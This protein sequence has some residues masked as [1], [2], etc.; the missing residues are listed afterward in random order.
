MNEFYDT[1]APFFRPISFVVNLTIFLSC[2]F[3]V[4][5]GQIPAWHKQLIYFMAWVALCICAT[6]MVGM[7]YGREHTF[8]YYQIGIIFES[9]FN[10]AVAVIGVVFCIRYYKGAYAEKPVTKV[11]PKLPTTVRTATRN[12]AKKA[13]RKKAPVVITKS[14]P[15]SAK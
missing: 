10:G 3:L 9:L 6:L 13:A 1:I 4:L 7:V 8:S 5:K 15:R 12:V 14:T 2:V 11:A